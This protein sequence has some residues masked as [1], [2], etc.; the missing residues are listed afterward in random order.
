MEAFALEKTAVVQPIQNQPEGFVMAVWFVR[1]DVIFQERVIAVF[2][3][4]GGNRVA[5]RALRERGLIEHLDELL[6]VRGPRV[7]R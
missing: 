6:V 7:R 4:H 5:R 1:K 2:D 3:K